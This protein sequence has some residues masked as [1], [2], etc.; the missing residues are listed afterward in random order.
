MR[1]DL[2]VHWKSDNFANCRDFRKSTPPQQK[3]QWKLK[4]NNHLWLRLKFRFVRCLQQ[5]S[6][7]TL[8]WQ[9][10]VNNLAARLLL[11]NFSVVLFVLEHSCLPMYQTLETFSLYILSEHQPFKFRKFPKMRQK[12]F[13][14]HREVLRMIGSALPYI[15]FPYHNEYPCL[16]CVHV[17]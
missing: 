17:S 5:M 16:A 13:L 1:S 11:K 7:L 9:D 2:C 10:I 8:I 15:C 3:R 14:T 4:K 6:F 12:L